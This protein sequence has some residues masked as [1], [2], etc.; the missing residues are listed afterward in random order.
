MACE[1][2]PVMSDDSL[3]QND[4]I[5]KEPCITRTLDTLIV[6]QPVAIKNYF[7]YLQQ[8]EECFN[9]QHKFQINEYILVHANSWILDRLEKTDYYEAKAKGKII[10]N[11][12]EEIIFQTGDTILL[13]DSIMTNELSNKLNRMW[14]DVN[15]P[16]FKLRVYFKES[17]LVSFPIRVG[18][19][20]KRYLAMID[21]EEDLRTKTGKGIILKVNKDP[22]YRNP[23]DNKK[24]TSTKR[25]DGR[26]TKLPRIPCLSP[27]LNGHK[28]GQLIHPT[29]NPVTLGKA[30]S[31]GCIGTGEA[32]AWFIYYHAPP[33]TPIRIRYE[34]RNIFD[35]TDSTVFKDIY[36][37]FE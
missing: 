22:E 26:H 29:T 3:I 13:P 16:E 2:F 37:K 6:Q 31:N 23:V 10:D 35:P 34:L 9:E 32:A 7:E 4:E 24:Y 12:P 5:E 36:Q 1:S 8:V 14:I 30:Y 27:E 11:Q 25:D 20:K 18:Q 21:R 33:G 15:I 17:L 19:N 28:W